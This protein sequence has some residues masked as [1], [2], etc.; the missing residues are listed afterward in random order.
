MLENVATQS[1]ST[2]F[3]KLCIDSTYSIRAINIYSKI[4]F[5]VTA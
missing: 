3:Y 5:N 1:V 4:A 2:E